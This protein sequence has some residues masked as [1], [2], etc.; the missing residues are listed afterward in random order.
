MSLSYVGLKRISNVL[1]VLLLACWVALP[2]RRTVMPRQWEQVVLYTAFAVVAM[3]L[4]WIFLMKILRATGGI[5][6]PEC[7]GPLN[8]TWEVEPGDVWMVCPACECAY[9]LRRGGFQLVRRELSGEPQRRETRRA[10]APLGQE[11]DGLRHIM[12]TDLGAIP[13]GSTLHRLHNMVLMLM[14]VFALVFGPVFGYF[15]VGATA[16]KVMAAKRWVETPCV[17]LSESE[18]AEGDAA[19]QGNYWFRIPYS[20]SVNGRQFA[21]DR[22]WFSNGLWGNYGEA[23]ARYQPGTRTVCYVNPDD[24]EE[25]VLNRRFT[26][27]LILPAFIPLGMVVFGVGGIGYSIWRMRR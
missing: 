18:V 27:D 20:Y 12:R 21:C 4:I 17:I 19:D 1:C 10:G 24:P 25:A 8:D 9:C 23:I 11:D 2:L 7:D 22:Y 13:P 6:C 26:S 15:F 5:T 3:F 16:L 14:C